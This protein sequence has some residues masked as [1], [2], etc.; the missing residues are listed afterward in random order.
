MSA[1]KSS[2]KKKSKKNDMTDVFG[3]LQPYLEKLIDLYNIASPYI[4]IAVSNAKK[5]FK[6]IEPYYNKYWKA[7]YIQVF[8]G[9]VLLFF[10]G[11]FAMTIA[12]YMAIQLSGWKTI[13]ES[14]KILKR[15]YNEGMEA[16]QNDPNAKKFFDADGDGK[17]SASE[18]GSAG[19]MLVSGTA[20]QKKA[21][22]LNLRCVFVA[23]DP[24]EVKLYNIYK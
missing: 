9:F 24:Q 4:D 3:K 5:G 18:I 14:W 2:D 17:I 21:V 22:L 7:E 8:I 11:T 12:C 16:F 20:E 15:N 19:K 13:Q 1:T 6:Q 23:I 10:G